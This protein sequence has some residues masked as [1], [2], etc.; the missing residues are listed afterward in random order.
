MPALEEELSLPERTREQIEAAMQGLDPYLDARPLVM[1]F[2]CQ[3]S[4]DR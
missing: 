4:I 2:P 3:T 1:I